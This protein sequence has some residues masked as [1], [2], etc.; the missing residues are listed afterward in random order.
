MMANRLTSKARRTLAAIG[1]AAIALATAPPVQARE[2]LRAA[3][4]EAAAE[5]VAENLPLTD[6]RRAL[7]LAGTVA[8]YCNMSYPELATP[9]DSSAG[10]DAASAAAAENQAVRQAVD[11][12][13]VTQNLVAAG[14]DPGLAKL[15]AGGYRVARESYDRK[16]A[17]QQAALHQSGEDP[18]QELVKAANAVGKLFHLAQFKAPGGC[19]HSLPIVRR[20]P[21]R[22]VADPPDATVYLITQFSFR[23]CQHRFDDPYSVKDC[24]AWAAV[25]SGVAQPINGTYDY[26]AVWPDGTVDRQRAEFPYVGT[27]PTDIRLAK[28]MP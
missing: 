16:T 25:P 7:A 19:A 14:M 20:T 6:E 13:V 12:A 3:R 17:A 18:D 15:L 22:F 24:L 23:V 2:S 26:S 21:Y 10:P 9:F 4:D 5:Y 28:P 11:M 8:P 27:D 1:V